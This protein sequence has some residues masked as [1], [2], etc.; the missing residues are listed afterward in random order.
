MRLV[1]M[2]GGTIQQQGW[3][4]SR[5]VWFSLGAGC[6]ERDAP[7]P[8]K[9]YPSPM[10]TAPPESK[11]I[12]YLWFLTNWHM[13]VFLAHKAPRPQCVV[14]MSHG[15]G[16]STAE[17]DIQPAGLFAQRGWLFLFTEVALCRAL[18]WCQ[19]YKDSLLVKVTLYYILSWSKRI[20]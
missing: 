3:R 4:Y 20:K 11:L 12:S 7:P 18:A 5:G 2:Y 17:T 6:S 1:S 10:P 15:C 19:S 13:Q 14:H 16:L 8:I 9:N